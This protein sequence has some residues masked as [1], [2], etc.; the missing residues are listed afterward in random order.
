MRWRL[1]GDGH[2]GHPTADRPD[3]DD[4]RAG[5]NRDDRHHL[6]HQDDVHDVV[7]R[8]LALRVRTRVV[9]LRVVRRLELGHGRDQQRRHRRWRRDYRWRRHRRRRDGWRRDGWRQHERPE[10]ADRWRWWCH[11]QRRHVHGNRVELGL[12]LG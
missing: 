5:V 6:D 12:R 3:R 1:S 8:L 4:L 9:R 10:P 11:S 2:I 7:E